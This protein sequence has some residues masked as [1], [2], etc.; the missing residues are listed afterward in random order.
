MS[1]FLRHIQNGTAH[2][3]SRFVP[4][5]VGERAL[6]SVRRDAAPLIDGVEG[7]AFDGDFLALKP[8][9]DE[10][11]TRTDAIAVAA[12]FLS[13]HYGVPLVGEIYP[14]I[15]NWGETPEAEIDRAAIPWFGTCGFGVHVNGFVR[16][17]DGLYL[18]VAKRA[19][20]RRIDPGKLDNLIGGGL[21]LGYTVEENLK[22]EAWEEAGIE[23]ALAATAK[24]AGLLRYKK[25]MMK[26]V[27]NDALFVFDLELPE[28][29][30]PRNTDGEVE[31]FTLLPAA[32][33][34][35]I[36]AKTDDFKFNCNLVMIDF[37]LRHSVIGKDDPEYA[38]L[39]F[40]R[41]SPPNNQGAF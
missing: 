23:A 39:I 41:E 13:N 12:R 38:E 3:P 33:V 16:K 14:V 19:E 15:E 28:S 4:F 24:P 30:T 34:A 40:W 11:Q 20:D 8:A 6:G 32:E 36:V 21:P 22:K 18:W 1:G 37:F 26:G 27:R 7:F 10:P 29:F 35:D 17:P 2:T 31:S 25:D 9:P 5:I